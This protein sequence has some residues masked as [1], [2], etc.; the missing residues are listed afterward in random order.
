MRT[1]LLDAAAR[2]LASLGTDEVLSLR[3]VARAAGVSPNAVYL[4]F[5][6]REELVLAVLKRLFDELAQARDQ[7]ETEAAARGGDAWQR[8]LARSLAY[9]SWGLREPGAY[10]VLYEGRAI[11]TLANPQDAA[12]GQ[13]MLDR[14][15]VLIA[16]LVAGGRAHPVG[17]VERAGI[18]VWTGLHGIVSLRINKDTID[19]PDAHVLA[20]E[21]VTAIVRPA[22][23]DRA[24]RSR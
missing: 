20:S 17:G 9:V 3:A 13:I 4:H 2:L 19:W 14:T 23:Q 15:N 6:D 22:A 1:D 18:L 7:A 24:A 16:E 11:P 5:A 10:R 21:T 12:F 8:L